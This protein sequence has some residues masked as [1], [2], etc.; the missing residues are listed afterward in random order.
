MELLLLSLLLS[1]LQL[2]LLLSQLL[3]L[4]LFVPHGESDDRRSGSGTAQDRP[5]G[6]PRGEP[7]RPHDM[8]VLD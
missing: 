2:L 8:A 1:L 6:E 4:L 7:C 3:L 5:S